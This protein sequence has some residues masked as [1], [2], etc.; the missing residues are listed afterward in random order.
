M[1]NLLYAALATD[2]AALHATLDLDARWLLMAVALSF[3]PPVFNAL[4]VW[5][6]GRL[7]APGFR[8]TAALH[9]VLVAEVGAAVTPTAVGGAPLKVAALARNGLGTA[10]GVALAALGGL[11]DAFF[12]IVTISLAA[13]HT[14][15][16]PR[17]MEDFRE[18]A[19]TPLPGIGSLLIWPS[20]AIMA[21]VAICLLR[22]R[23]AARL[24]ARA[25]SWWNDLRANIHLVR[26]RGLGTFAGNVLLAGLQWSSRLSILTALVAGLGV[27]LEPLRTA[28]LQWLCF[29]CMALVPTPG[30]VGGAEAA[31]VLVFGRELPAAMLP[32]AMA[33]WRMVTF[34]G[35]N[36]VGLAVLILLE[37]RGRQL[38]VALSA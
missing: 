37:R 12:I 4:R 25:S 34:Y 7:L 10:G 24:R 11:E 19:A 31:F 38:Q 5:R 1:G 18:I 2:R 8:F 32:M 26:D 3:A 29:T 35:L 30:A 22:H 9:T 21:A 6:W 36:L 13:W 15:L 17:F 20:I 27:P 33:A 23:R 14:G 28:V 16:L